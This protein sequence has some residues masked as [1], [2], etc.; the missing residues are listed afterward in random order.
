MNNAQT[1]YS[2]EAGESGTKKL[3]QPEPHP[4]T[5]IVP[6]T[7]LPSLGRLALLPVGDHCIIPAAMSNRKRELFMQGKC[8]EIR[9][10]GSSSKLYYIYSWEM[11][12][13]TEL[14]KKPLTG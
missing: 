13:P 7:S 9:Q 3:Y 11:S 8:D 5:H 14:A 1:F 2:Y 6:I 10:P 12:W 4:V